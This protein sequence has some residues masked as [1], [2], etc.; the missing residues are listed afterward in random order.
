MIVT[1]T[2]TI[3]GREIEQYLD[4]ISYETV[5]AV[6]FFKDFFTYF[7]DMFG[8]RS[9]TLEK[10]M[11]DARMAAMLQLRNHA[12]RIKADAVV[13]L[14]YQMS[15]PFSRGGFLAVVLTG[16]A[17][18]LKPLDAPNAPLRPEYGLIVDDH[19]SR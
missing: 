4:V 15:M 6:N 8:G 11:R 16:T 2:P 3:A 12:K 5:M 13:G 18:R 1:T 14:Q 10:T 17:V 19:P 7:T 9:A